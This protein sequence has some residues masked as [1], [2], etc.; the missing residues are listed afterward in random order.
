MGHRHDGTRGVAQRATEASEAASAATIR[1]G[2]RRRLA[3]IVSR[4]SGLA[5]VWILGDFHPST[6]VLHA[7]LNIGR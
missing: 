4:M 2:I 5:S 3:R 7:G 6:Q 1:R